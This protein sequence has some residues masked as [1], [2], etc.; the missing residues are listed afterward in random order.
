M[1]KPKGSYSWWRLTNPQGEAHD[2]K[3]WTPL[4]NWAP[5]QLGW[6]EA[7]SSISCY[8]TNDA[9]GVLLHPGESRKTDIHFVWSLAFPFQRVN[10][11]KAFF[12]CTTLRNAASKL[13]WFFFSIENTVPTS[14]TCLQVFHP[15]VFHAAIR[16]PEMQYAN[17]RLDWHQLSCFSELNF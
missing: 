14:P 3:K 12:H 8:L 2:H 5:I 7:C 15:E 11:L 16:E 17:F 9:A 6:M 1:I 4:K 13:W 10:Y